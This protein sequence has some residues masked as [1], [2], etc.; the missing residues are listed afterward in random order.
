MLN[1]LRFE[2]TPPPPSTDG[3]AVLRI[4]VRNAKCFAFRTF[5]IRTSVDGVKKNFFKTEEVGQAGKGGPKKSVFGRTSL[6]DDPLSTPP[7]YD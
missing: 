7:S 2:D 6:M 1:I 3:W 5:T 4:N